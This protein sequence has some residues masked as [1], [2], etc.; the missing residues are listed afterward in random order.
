MRRFLLA[1]TVGTVGAEPWPT[2]EEAGWRDPRAIEER[3][4]G[5]LIRG[6]EQRPL[7]RQPATVLPRAARI[8]DEP[9]LERPQRIAILEDLDWSVAAVRD[10]P[11]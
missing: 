8:R 7:G 11:G 3:T 10:R 6:D 9:V 1:L 5:D 4:E 2:A